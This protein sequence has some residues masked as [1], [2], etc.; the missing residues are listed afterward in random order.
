MSATACHR[1]RIAGGL[2][3]S[4]FVLGTAS[5]T[6]AEPGSPTSAYYWLAHWV[7]VGNL[8][9]AAAQFAEG[10]VVIVAPS[11][12]PEAPCVGRAAIRQRYLVWIAAQPSARAVF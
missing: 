2:A 5:A 10:A 1:K 4:V 7:S 9:A 12:P 11:C 3:A 6:A 8:D